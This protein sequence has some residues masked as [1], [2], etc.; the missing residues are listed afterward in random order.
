[1]LISSNPLLELCC[2]TG[3]QL[4]WAPHVRHDAAYAGWGCSLS[5]Q[6]NRL[7]Q[8]HSAKP[9]GPE[10]GY[11]KTLLNQVPALISGNSIFWWVEIKC[12][13]HIQCILLPA[14]SFFN[15]EWFRWRSAW[16][17]IGWDFPKF[18]S[19]SCFLC[20]PDI[21]TIIIIVSFH[22]LFC[23]SCCGSAKSGWKSII[24]LGHFQWKW[25]LC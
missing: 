13:L 12:G 16:K 2:S 21:L 17:G 5:Q 3:Q 1:M 24:K 25:V 4:L 22:F 14:D 6:E 19:L 20:F 7:P 10:W 15:R 18:P 23:S 8:S 11:G 9:W